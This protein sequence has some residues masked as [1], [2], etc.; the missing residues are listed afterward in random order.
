MDSLRA[1]AGAFI[2]PIMIHELLLSPT[3]TA[4]GSHP[5]CVVSFTA[6]TR[7][8]IPSGTPT[9]STTCKSPWRVPAK[10]YR[11]VTANGE[12]GARKV[13]TLIGQGVEFRTA[14]EQES[15]RVDRFSASSPINPQEL[16]RFC[17]TIAADMSSRV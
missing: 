6:V 11:W 15:S 12:P 2:A 1:I 7:V 4:S 16:A 3:E 9:L 8:Q 10:S 13:G 17:F 14:L 5:C